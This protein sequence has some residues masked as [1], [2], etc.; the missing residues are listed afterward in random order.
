MIISQLSKKIDMKII[1]L[2]V[3]IKMNEKLV[4]IMKIQHQIITQLQRSNAIRMMATF[5][6]VKSQIHHH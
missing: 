6:S 5:L 4:A 3:V 1:Q 2:L